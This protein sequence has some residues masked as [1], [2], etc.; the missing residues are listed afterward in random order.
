MGNFHLE[1]KAYEMNLS[2][3]LTMGSRGVKTALVFKK[4]VVHV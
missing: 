4:K 2:D 1:T 3:M